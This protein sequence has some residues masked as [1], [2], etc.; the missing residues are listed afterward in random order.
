MPF[1]TADD[2]AFLSRASAQTEKKRLRTFSDALC[3]YVLAQLDKDWILD[4][5]ASAIESEKDP[6]VALWS[7]PVRTWTIPW[8]RYVQTRCPTREAARQYEILRNGWNTEIGLPDGRWCSVVRILSRSDFVDR[9]SEVLGPNFKV[10]WK[11]T[12]RI[13][14]QPEFVVSKMVLM[15]R[16]YPNGRPMDLGPVDHSSDTVYGTTLLLR[17]HEPIR[18]PPPTPRLTSSPP[19]I[20]RP[21]RVSSRVATLDPQDSLHCC[22]W[23]LDSE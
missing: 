22:R 4:Q 8:S 10:V 19:P 14:T 11:M 17:G 15:V 23:E 12:D 1:F 2:L 13:H 9:L 18:T 21:I 7:C 5:L 20:E 3:Q 6:A 16:Y